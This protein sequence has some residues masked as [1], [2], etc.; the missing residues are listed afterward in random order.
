M[1]GACGCHESC[2][3]A[4]TTAAQD[5]QYRDCDLKSTHFTFH[6]ARCNIC[7]SNHCTYP[8]ENEQ[9]K[10][11]HHR[12]ILAEVHVIR[13][14]VIFLPSPWSPWSPS[15]EDYHGSP[16]G[17]RKIDD[18]RDHSTRLSEVHTNLLTGVG[19]S[20]ALSPLLVNFTPGVDDCGDVV[21]VDIQIFRHLTVWD[22]ATDSSHV[23][24]V[25][26]SIGTWIAPETVIYDCFYNRGARGE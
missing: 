15:T 24:P 12:R 14:I 4:G 2:T 18:E 6:I 21:E 25:G 13:V 9:Y 22:Q 8:F 16:D 10:G 19:L 23:Q 1:T 7:C 3:A 17:H 20:V 26:S 5:D 11:K